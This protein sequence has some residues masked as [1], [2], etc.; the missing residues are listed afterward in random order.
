MNIP[1]GAAGGGDKRGGRRVWCLIAMRF[2][3]VYPQRR[4]RNCRRCEEQ[5][6]RALVHFG[7]KVPR[8][9]RLA[10]PSDDHE[11]R[12]SNYTS[13]D[14]TA[15]TLV[16]TSG[17]ST[18][19]CIVMINSRW[20]NHRDLHQKPSRSLRNYVIYMFLADA[21]GSRRSRSP[22]ARPPRRS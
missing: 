19:G 14:N 2:H 6:I 5:Y 8:T 21:I 13:I 16:V 1:S 22:G 20:T 4:K 18:R 12:S 17:R 7:A 15:R 11:G 9:F 10:A 3:D